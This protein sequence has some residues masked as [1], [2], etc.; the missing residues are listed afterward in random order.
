MKNLV[1]R[2]CR[3]FLFA[4][5]CLMVTLSLRAQLPDLGIVKL[6]IAAANQDKSGGV[7]FGDFEFSANSG[8]NQGFQWDD[9]KKY[10]DCSFGADVTKGDRTFNITGTFR[11]W[12]PKEGKFLLRKGAN[13]DDPP[14]LATFRLSIDNTLTMAGQAAGTEGTVILASFAAGKIA[15]SFDV[16]LGDSPIPDQVRHLYK[17][18]G[19]FRLTNGQ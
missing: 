7:P 15:G 1:S 11:I 9:E 2:K 4:P 19:T 18:T 6:N 12:H 8:S 13:A 14:N 17:L 5:I 3:R 10:I 16:T